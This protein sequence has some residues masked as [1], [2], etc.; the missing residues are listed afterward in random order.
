[1]KLFMSDAEIASHFRQAADKRKDLR[2]LADLNSCHVT[3]IKAALA[4][5]GI[6]MES[7]QNKLDG[8]AARKLYNQGHKDS[9]IAAALNVSP[10]TV[11]NW[12]LRNGLSS[13]RDKRR[14]QERDDRFQRMT[15]IYEAAKSILML[16]PQDANAKVRDC[17]AD[18]IVALFS[19]EA[20]NMVKEVVPHDISEQ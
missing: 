14:I 12:R 13:S 8:V 19:G 18:L 16:I 17:A 3:E 2:I 6:T 1:M 11:A 7:Q 20:E 15:K 4:R 10:S 5:E 9:E